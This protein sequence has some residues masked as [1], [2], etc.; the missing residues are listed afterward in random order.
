VKVGDTG[1]GRDSVHDDELSRAG[2]EVTSG[3]D[4]GDTAAGQSPVA[5]SAFGSGFG[6]SVFAALCSAIYLFPYKRAAALAP[7][8]VLAYALLIVAALTSA[9]FELWQR[10][11][12]PTRAVSATERR[13][14]WTISG[15]LSLL[16]ITGNYCGA[17]AVARL[18]PAVASVLLRTEIVFVGAMGALL[19]GESITLP[20]LLGAL[21]ALAGLSVMRWP[22]AL[23]AAG[24]G[25]LWALGGAASFGTMQVITRR[26]IARISPVRVNTARLWLAVGVWSL[27]PGTARAAFDQSLEFW[28]YVAVAGL[29]GPFLGRLLIMYSLQTLRAAHSALLLLLAPVFA[30]T[31]GLLVFGS[32]PSQRELIGGAIMLVGIALPSLARRSA[33][34]SAPPIA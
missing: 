26:V 20:L 19:L 33:A 23:D 10:R 18:E 7:A 5:S 31:I 8:D 32:V 29:F 9:A 1:N 25:A 2:A 16:A 11:S 3:D 14:F 27:V 30:F 13:T 28:G 6:F 17:Q 22:L 34:P 4:P 21:V 24:T 15:V 12:A